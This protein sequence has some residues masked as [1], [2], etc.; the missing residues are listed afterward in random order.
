M[1]TTAKKA[2]KTPNK[3]TP[4][5]A[6]P[7]APTEDPIDVV[8]SEQLVRRHIV[9][10]M[11][12]GVIPAPMIDVAAITGIQLKLLTELA[13]FYDVQ[14]ESSSLKN[15]LG[16]LVGGIGGVSAGLWGASLLKSIP[17]VGSVAGLVMVPILAGASTYAV[18]NVF[19]QHFESGGTFLT[20]DAK[21]AQA[22]YREVFD[23][24]KK[25]A[26]ELKEKLPFQKK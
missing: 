9:Y 26:T 22:Y 19:I 3:N 21:K 13:K 2:P 4:L 23:E 16:S 25:V 15:V 11:A 20:F 1:A 12:G 6:T 17:I 10:A 24:G 14:F 18:G 5:A 8:T 7:S